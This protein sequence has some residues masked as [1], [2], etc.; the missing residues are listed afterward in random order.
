MTFVLY[1]LATGRAH[2]QGQEAYTGYD[3]TVYGL[4]ETANVGIWN[5]ST[6]DFDPI[7]TD[8]RMTTL[9]FMELFTDAEFEGILTAAKTVVSVERYIMKMNAADFMDL[10]YQPTIDGIN[11]LAAGGLITTQRAAVI[12]N[13]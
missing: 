1:E 4:K 3:T 11:A 9:S 12:L 8:K 10:N 6:L 7:P 5:E 2:A 13:G